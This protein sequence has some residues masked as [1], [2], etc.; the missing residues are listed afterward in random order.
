MT[1]DPRLSRAGSAS[2]SA[3]MSGSSSRILSSLPRSRSA[4]SFLASAPASSPPSLGAARWA[5]RVSSGPA[6]PVLGP[7]FPRFRPM[8][9]RSSLSENCALIA[10]QAR[11]GGSV[12]RF[13]PSAGCA[14]PLGAAEPH[15][16]A[17]PL[18]FVQV[19]DVEPAQASV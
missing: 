19:R 17:R 2:A 13:R 14:R 4:T 6:A 18:T 9:L 7:S 10:V 5:S 11:A 16:A 1:E 8:M 12:E 15:R 3:R